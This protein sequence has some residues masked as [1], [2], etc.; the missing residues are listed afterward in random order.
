MGFNQVLL[1]MFCLVTARF[2][3]RFLLYYLLI[4][5]KPVSAINVSQLS[6]Y[7]VKSTK[8]IDRETLRLGAMG[9]EYDRR[10]MIVDL[11]GRFITQRQYPRMCLI[12]AQLDNGVLTLAADGVA[13]LTVTTAAGG[14]ERRLVTVWDD[15][16]DAEDCGDHAA[17]WLTRCLGV[18]CRLVFMPDDYQRL[19]NT[20]YARNSEIVSFADGFPLLL[21]SD[22]SLQ[23]LNA[24]LDS[25]I[26]THRFRPNIVVSGCDAFAEDHWKKIRIAG[27]EFD[28]A[29]SCT[30]CVIPSIDPA[31]GDKQREVIQVLA[32][33]RRRDGAI[34][35]GQ[36]LLFDRQ[37][38]LTVGDKVEILA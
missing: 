19:V 9:P 3:H 21:I 24:R 38:T 2:A 35:F 5:I 13:P 14:R 28:V 1:G 16:V 36:N 12:A 26:T 31:T 20:D 30:R 11:N 34:H 6:I 23:D 29:K 32:S 7:P 15:T 8:G 33:Y 10:W 37:G 25:A 17:T 22:A 27:I 4:G 18:D